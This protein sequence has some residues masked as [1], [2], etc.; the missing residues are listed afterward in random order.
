MAKSKV[1]GVIKMEVEILYQPA[2]TAA[3]CH[4]GPGDHLMAESG[5]MMAMKGPVDVKTTTK[6]KK[7]GNIFS[8]L[9][10]LVSGE[11]FFIN[12]FSTNSQGQVW[13]GTPLPGDILVKELHGEKLV[14]QGGGF[15]ACED[16]VE[17][18]LEWQGLKS[19][20]SGEGLFWIKAKGQGKILLESFG[21]IYPVQVNGEYIVDT[22]HIVAFEETLDFKISK[23]SSSWISAFLSG[24]GFV[25][26][27]KGTGTVWCQSH[28]PNAFGQELSPYLKTKSS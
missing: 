25:C 23:A 17:I 22:G 10:R 27:F 18:D 14:I 4:M 1:L 19:I 26:R 12:H 2:G 5:A 3:I 7:G 6:Q 15:L 8:G 24:E 21:F 13:L 28:N 9:K 20:F 16:G 11:S